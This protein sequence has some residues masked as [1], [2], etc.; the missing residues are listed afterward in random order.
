MYFWVDL[1]IFI[2]VVHGCN[3]W[4]KDY[5]FLFI[6]F[7]ANMN[8]V[9]SKYYDAPA[10]IFL[11]FDPTWRCSLTYITV[12]KVNKLTI[13]NCE[14]ELCIRI[15]NINIP[16]YVVHLILKKLLHFIPTSS[17]EFRPCAHSK[18]SWKRIYCT[19]QQIATTNFNQT[20]TKYQSYLYVN[21][22]NL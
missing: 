20:T 11:N 13:K 15:K 9:N 5:L 4:N 18:H 22:F 3:C 6:S 21:F 10:H 12:S 1:F 16:E 17:I 2:Y 7:K 14:I 8:R 19:M